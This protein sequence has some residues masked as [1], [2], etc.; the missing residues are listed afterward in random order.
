MNSIKF[1]DT[2]LRDGEQAPGYSMN[3]A[4]K[5]EFAKQLERLGVDVIEAGFAISSDEDFESIRSIAQTIKNA[6]VCSLSRLVKGDIDRSAQAIKDAARPRIHTFIAT[7]DIHMQHKLKMSPN[8]VLTRVEELVRYA[9]GQCD[10]IEFSAEDATRSDWDFLVQVYNTAI[11]SGATVLNVPD[12]VGYT[13]PNEMYDLITYLRGK[14]KGIDKVDISVHCHN[15]LGMAVANTLAAVRAGATQVE[16]AINGIGERAGNASLEEVAMALHTRKS[17]FGVETGIN[18]RQIYRTSKMLS[19][20]TG[21]AINPSKPIVGANAFAHESGIHQHGVLNE[22]LTYEIMSPESVGVYQNKMVLGK[23]S[24]KHAFEDRLSELGFTLTPEQLEK[25]FVDFKKL[26]DKK[27]VISDRDIEALVGSE[28]VQVAETFTLESF[29]VQSGTQTTA[30]SS[31][32][33]AKG[34][35]VCEDAALGTGPIDA[36]FKAVDRITG[37]ES[38]LVNYTI[39]SV[40]EGEDALGEVV[41]KL[42]AASG[43]IVTGRGL[44]TDIIEASIKAYVNGIN[45]VLETGLEP[46]PRLEEYTV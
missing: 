26:T 11:A 8:Q 25:V 39:Q 20:I 31:V 29:T 1:F 6:S 22:R 12:T 37:A 43:E 2:T 28:K 4:D 44:S 34:D 14:V 33:L 32:R 5:L 10:D 24:G 3:V 36:A 27:R 38:E 23:H 21:V 15:D 42:K 9:K 41:V 18:T 46:Q 13:T 35:E 17:Y 30:T 19:T 40:T 45:K 16:G 7:S